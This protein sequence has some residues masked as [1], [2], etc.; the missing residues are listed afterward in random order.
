MLL[1][2]EQEIAL[3]PNNAQHI[4]D[5]LDRTLERLRAVEDTFNSVVDEKLIESCIYEQKSLLLRVEYLIKLA[6]ENNISCDA[7]NMLLK[8]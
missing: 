4:R 6:A 5:E 1:K 3:D 2:S 7:F 8:D